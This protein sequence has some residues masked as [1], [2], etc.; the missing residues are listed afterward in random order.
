MEWSKW[1]IDDQFFT[2]SASMKVL[3]IGIGVTGSRTY[4]MSSGSTLTPYGRLNL[5]HENAT[6]TYEDTQF[7]STSASDSQVAL[8]ANAGVAWG[9]SDR[10]VLM[11]ELQIDGNDG[12]FLGVD[13]RP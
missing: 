1:N 9:V 5:R 7:G 3:E 13:Y 2:G 8:G 6:F 12:L 11:G 4:R 10:F